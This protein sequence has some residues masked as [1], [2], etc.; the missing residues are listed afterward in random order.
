MGNC[1][2]RIFF[3]VG[4]MLHPQCL[5]QKFSKNSSNLSELLLE[6][7]KNW[8]QSRSGKSELRTS[9]MNSSAGLS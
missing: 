2:K 9:F 8:I 1:F 5:I 3:A 7:Y 6:K 4:Q